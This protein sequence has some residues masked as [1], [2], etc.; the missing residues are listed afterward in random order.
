MRELDAAIVEG[1]HAMER[2][3]QEDH[4][5]VCGEQKD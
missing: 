5:D 4:E 2:F 1:E 3:N